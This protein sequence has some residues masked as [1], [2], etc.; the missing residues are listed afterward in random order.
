MEQRFDNY[1]ILIADD[2]ALQLET[3]KAIAEAIGVSCETAI[4]GDDALQKLLN[5]PAGYYSLFLSDIFMP[6]MK[7][8]ETA[9]H[10][11]TS[12]HPDARSLPIIGISADTDPTLY[13]TAIS[14]GMSSMTLKPV[15][16]AAL[17]AFFTL[18]LTEKKANTV[19]AAQMQHRIE[20]ERK[21]R[22]F[23]QTISTDIRVPLSSVMEFATLLKNGE[24]TGEEA[25][26]YA[27]VIISATERIYQ[28]IN[29]CQL[30][31]ENTGAL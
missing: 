29:N 5:A 28:V 8:F 2:N 31:F 21:Q 16:E 26:N 12:D 15:T 25:K 13:D 20:A 19:F 18:F 6:K 23:I 9:M 22:A 11:R 17:T 4:D 30:D 24:I 27:D 14:S 7:G 1:R 10:F 3:L